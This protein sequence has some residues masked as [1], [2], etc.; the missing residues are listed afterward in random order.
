M[1]VPLVRVV[2]SATTE[3]HLSILLFVCACWLFANRCW[4]SDCRKWS[5]VRRRADAWGSGI[6]SVALLGIIVIVVAGDRENLVNVGLLLAVVLLLINVI[7]YLAGW[8]VGGMANY[9]KPVE[10]P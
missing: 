9:P 7:G 3:N 6:A 10:E 5:L 1:T 8:F 4:F 2:A